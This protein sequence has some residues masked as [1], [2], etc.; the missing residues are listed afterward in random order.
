MLYVSHS[1]EEVAELCDQVIV[2]RE[3]KC[4]RISPP[5]EIFEASTSL[6]LK[7]GLYD[8]AR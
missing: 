4:L 6:A 7:P 8:S 1:P 2:L 3:G 5:A